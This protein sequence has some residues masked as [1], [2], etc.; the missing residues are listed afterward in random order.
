MNR[1]TDEGYGLVSHSVEI[2][3]IPK[4]PLY[5]SV[6]RSNLAFFKR[7]FDPIC[8]NRVANVND[9]YGRFDLRAFSLG[10]FSILFLTFLGMAISVI[11]NS[12]P[13]DTD[14]VLEFISIV[15]YLGFHFA[16]FMIVSSTAHE[17]DCNMNY[18]ELNKKDASF[19]YTFRQYLLVVALEAITYFVYLLCLHFD[20][21]VP[22]FT[23]LLITLVAEVAS[24]AS[25]ISYLQTCFWEDRTI[26]Y[27][28]KIE[29]SLIASF[30]I[31]TIVC[32]ISLTLSAINLTNSSI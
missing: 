5:F 4:A 29:K 11:I 8:C 24:S 32:W 22:S 20:Q 26:G 27:T 1:A 23:F 16:Q 17:E 12:S 13:T 3:V 19:E 7:E 31:A 28:N 2:P 30:L 9:P 15:A 25:F 10:L 18:R 21:V 14:Y 6:T